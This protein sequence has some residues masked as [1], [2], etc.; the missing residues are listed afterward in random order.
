MLTIAC[1]TRTD[2]G[3]VRRHN[4][5]RVFAGERLW[6]V[7]DGM[8]GHAA[9]DVASALVVARLEQLDA[10]PEVRQRDVVEALGEANAAILRHG[11]EHP[12]AR[13]LGSTVTG[14]ARVVVGGAEHWA[15]FNVGDSRVYRFVDGELARATIDHSET[16]E[17]VLLGVITPEEARTHQSR[18]VITRSLG[19]VQPPLVDVF[20]LPRTA[21]ERFLL[22]SD[23]LSG[24]LTDP[25]IEDILRGEPDAG[26]AADLL[27]EAAL[28]SGGHDNVSVVVVDVVGDW[29]PAVNEDTNPRIHL[30]GV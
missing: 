20:V 23:G 13:G 30:E 18:N 14:L 9:G 12:E 3:R 5:D 15:V 8:G 4:E 28:A 26:R 24:E 29:P 25:E 7:A 11:D 17:L 19:S 1:G 6:A 10:Q 21:G 27:V 16:E 2:V 22:C